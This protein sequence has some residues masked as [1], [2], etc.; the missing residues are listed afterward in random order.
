MWRRE[1]EQETWRPP[2]YLPLSNNFSNS[3]SSAYR[4]RCH[5]VPLPQPLH[6][7]QNYIYKR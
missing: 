1:K 3:L 2:E 6:A 5:G 7:G 4:L